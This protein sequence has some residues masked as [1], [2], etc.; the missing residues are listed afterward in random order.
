MGWWEGGRTGGFISENPGVESVAGIHD[1]SPGFPCC[2]LVCFALLACFACFALL[3]F[4]Y[5]MFAIF[6]FS[7]EE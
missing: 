2:L 1:S 6:H 4:C 3:C 5:A 7:L